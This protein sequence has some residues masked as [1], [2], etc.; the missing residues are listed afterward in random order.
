MCTGTCIGRVE[1]VVNGREEAKLAVKYPWLTNR[2]HR[3]P[4]GE[5]GIGC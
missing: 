5:D 4:F 1:G 2:S 3:I